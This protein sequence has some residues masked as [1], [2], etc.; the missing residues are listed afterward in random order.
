MPRVNLD[1]NAT[2]PLRPAARE[3][4]L[5]WLDAANPSSVHSEGRAARRAV[6]DARESVRGA[7]GAPGGTIVFTSGA[8]EAAALA[9]SPEWR[10][11]RSPLR[12]ERLLVAATEHP[13]VLGGGRFSPDAVETVAVD[14]SGLLDLGALCD[15]LADG[16][17]LVAV[18]LANNETGVVQDIPAIARVVH[19]AGGLLVCDATQGVG[20]I[21]TALDVLGADVLIASSHKVGGPMGAGAVVARRGGPLPLPVA[22][23]GGQEDGHRGGTENVAAIAG[24]AAALDEVVDLAP[25]ARV[26]ALHDRLETRARSLG[27]V[28][29]GAGAPRLPNTTLLSFAHLTAET[30]QIAFDLDGIAVS[31]GSACASGKVGPSHV[32]AAMGADA[33][34]ALRLSLGRETTDEDIDRATATLER[35]AARDAVKRQTLMRAA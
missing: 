35:L 21:P 9:L 17:A 18:M 24:F 7:L 12:F 20:R 3:A 26:R 8:T 2:A 6:E 29:H 31:T 16:P 15:A 28:I 10:D 27:F 1:H 32:L 23:A 19:E 5:R 13:C 34:G 14:G 25:I 4:A 30:A 11:G 22:R 33:P